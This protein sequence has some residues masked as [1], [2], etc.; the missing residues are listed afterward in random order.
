MHFAVVLNYYGL[1]KVPE[2]SQA[3]E[4]DLCVFLSNRDIAYEHGS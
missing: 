4:L 3:P 2:Q 1:I